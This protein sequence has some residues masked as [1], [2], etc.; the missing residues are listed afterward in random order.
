MWVNSKNA[1]KTAEAM[2]AKLAKQTP[3]NQP[4][5]VSSK[6]IKKH[7]QAIVC[8][9][10]PSVLRKADMS[11]MTWDTSSDLDVDASTVG[12][13][14]NSSTL[15]RAV[16]PNNKAQDFLRK[17][18]STIEEQTIREIALDKLIK[19]QKA[20]A[21]TR[22]ENENE[23]GAFLAMKKVKK[24][25]DERDRVVQAMDLAMDAAI[26]IESAISLA[27]SKAISERNTETRSVWFMVDIGE[28]SRVLQEVQRALL[29][30]VNDTASFDREQ[31]LARIESF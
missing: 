9:S 26:A 15:P 22:Y 4:G 13:G 3:T 6:S 28:Q 16:L 25:E 10:S 21:K 8:S 5:R 29:D 20:L 23:T 27:K 14:S 17:V 19:D 12:S 1:Y 30:R 2:G 31:L 7:P 18:Q 24:L 11:E